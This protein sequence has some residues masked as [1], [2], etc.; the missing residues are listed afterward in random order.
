MASSSSSN[1]SGRNAGEGGG[2]EDTAG[3]DGAQLQ[4]YR[5]MCE[6]QLQECGMAPN[7]IAGALRLFGFL[8]A[9]IQTGERYDVPTLDIN[10]FRATFIEETG[11]D[12]TSENWQRHLVSD[13]YIYHVRNMEYGLYEFECPNRTTSIPGFGQ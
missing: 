9:I 5:L 7:E 3:R 6:N 11:A 13:I 10:D 12:R 1:E 8:A 2:G 4:I